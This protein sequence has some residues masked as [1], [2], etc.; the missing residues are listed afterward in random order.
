MRK[1]K[2]FTVVLAVTCTALL[3]GGCGSGGNQKD[4]DSKS[5]DDSGGHPVITMNAPYR[6]MS[7]FVDKVKEKYPEINLE[8][9]PYNGQNTS[10]YMFDMRKTGEMTDIYFTTY[11]VP[12]RYDDKA[13]F[14]DLS[15]CDFTGDYV[16]SR[17]R[18]VTLDGAIYMLP[19][20]YNALG[21]TYNKTLLD[22]NGWK[23]PESFKELEE[24]APKVEEA[25]YNLCLDQLQYPGFGFQFLCNIADTGF[26]STIDGLTWQENF[27]NGDASV[28]DT[29][30]MVEAVQSIEKWRDLGM[31]N[32]NGTPDSDSDTKDEMLKGNTLF[33]LGNSN[34]L[35]AENDATDD[36]RLM[37]YLSE[38]G[39]QNVFVLN[40]SR[41][42]GLNKKLGEKGNEQKLEDAMHVME[43]ISTV[44]GMESMEPSQTNS[45][46]IPLKDA[47]VG[48]DSYYA[49]VLDE[50]NSGHTASFIYSGW[51]NIIV[52]VGETMIEYIK[53]NAE[54][55]DVIRAL[56]DNQSLITENKVEAFTTVTETLD[57]DTC[58]KLVGICF[59]QA[60]KADAALI[61]TNPWMYD[62]DA[63]EMNKEGV[64]GALFPMGVSDQEIVSILP[65]GWSDNIQTV[66]LTGKRIKELMQTG[67]ERSENSVAFPYI[68]AAKEGMEFEDDTTYTIVICGATD[69]VQKEGNIQDSGVLGLDAAKEYLS[70]FKT[71]SSKDIVWE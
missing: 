22:K 20:G 8:V 19:M 12:G 30:E 54:V 3:L 31:L 26:L 28:S 70:Q 53:G 67:Y 1:R 7:M 60:V 11:Y 42:V 4:T 6:N 57:M 17:L 13:D 46:I 44:D 9:I 52:P 35:T 71:L 51:E 59:A 66:T 23:L 56:D 25:G 18:E 15:G 65:T 55:D 43:V 40:V 16:Q 63:Y 47:E 34:D 58:A 38:E 39:D 69:E 5:A 37:P 24:L 10:A 62:Q 21:I 68:L 50:L 61:S 29:P 33:L 2:I 45:R 14:L 36:F 41:Y 64:S 48:K 27:L 32:A 49:D